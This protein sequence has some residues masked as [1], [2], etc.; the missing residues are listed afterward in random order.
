MIHWIVERS[1]RCLRCHASVTSGMQ[2][3]VLHSEV[4]CLGT[5][6]KVAGVAF[7]GRCLTSSTVSLSHLRRD[8]GKL[9]HV[10]GTGSWRDHHAHLA[11]H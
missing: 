8:S 7:L 3:E 10:A 11:K 5:C 6:Y 4:L 9:P 2:R 1:L